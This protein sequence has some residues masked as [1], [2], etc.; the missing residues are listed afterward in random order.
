MTMN[1]RDSRWHRF[2]S[3]RARHAKRPRTPFG[4]SIVF[5][6]VALLGFAG[7]ASCGQSGDAVSGSPSSNRATEEALIARNSPATVEEYAQLCG[8]G[9]RYIDYATVYEMVDAAKE[10]LGWFHEIKPPHEVEEVH[11]A[12]Q[13][14][15]QEL[16]NASKLVRGDQRPSQFMFAHLDQRRIAGLLRADEELNSATFELD[17]DVRKTLQEHNCMG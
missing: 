10:S 8:S 11:R 5:G 12:Q 14:F 7:A 6:L 13:R 17:P 3:N 9:K 2:L 1:G 4:S 16:I 15:S